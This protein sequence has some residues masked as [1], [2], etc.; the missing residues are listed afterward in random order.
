MKNEVNNA[1]ETSERPKKGRIFYGWWV[2]LAAAAGSFAQSTTTTEALSIYIA[3]LSSEFGWSRTLISGGVSLGTLMCAPAALLIGPILDKYGAKW[4]VVCSTV[5][6]GLGFIGIALSTTPAAFYASVIVMRVGGVGLLGLAVTTAVAN[7]FSAKRGRVVAIAAL[8][9]SLSTIV[10]PPIAQ[11]LM[12]RYDYRI[13]LYFVAATVLAV[14]IVPALLFMKRRPE[15]IGLRPDGVTEAQE[16]AARAAAKKAKSRSMVEQT[17]HDWTLAESMKTSAMWLL[18]FSIPLSIMVLAGT[19]FHQTTYLIQQGL[20]TVAA[21]GSLSFFAIGT[22]V[23]RGAWGLLAERIPVRL[24]MAAGALFMV[25]AEILFLSAN[26]VPVAFMSAFFLG[27]GVS[28]GIALEPVI[29]ANYFGRLH[30]G[31]IRGV[32]SVSR[33]TMAAAGPLLSGLVYDAFGRYFII[34]LVYAGIMVCTALMMALTMPPT[35]A[36][37]GP[38]ALPPG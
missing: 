16:K 22:G 24:C 30:L 14:T 3:P 26:N 19:T 10:L 36:R 13:S 4:V 12:D 21:A 34:F 28:G 7:W 1:I 18:I 11:L 31:S 20:P 5:A 2:V 17:S 25:L 38:E 15:D 32:A 35:R 29:Y 6:I 27:V 8:G 33:W 9:G 37:P 23:S